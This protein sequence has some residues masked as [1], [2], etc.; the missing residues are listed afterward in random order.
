MQSMNPYI[1]AKHQ[2]QHQHRKIRGRGARDELDGN[3]YDGDELEE[4][5]EEKIGRNSRKSKSKGRKA[6]K[7]KEMTLDIEHENQED[8]M[9]DAPNRQRKR[10]S[11]SEERRVSIN[12]LDAALGLDPTLLDPPESTLLDPP[13]SPPPPS[14]RSKSAP[15][16]RPSILDRMIS[17]DALAS[18]PPAS[19]F[20]KVKTTV[21]GLSAFKTITSTTP[22]AFLQPQQPDSVPTMIE[23]AGERRRRKSSRRKSTDVA[24][25]KTPEVLPLTEGNL[26]RSGLQCEDVGPPTRKT[27]KPIP[28][29]D[30]PLVQKRSRPRA[31]SLGK[32]RRRRPST[33][34]GQ[35]ESLEKESKSRV[36][37][38][39]KPTDSDITQ[40][41]DSN[42]SR[43]SPSL[44]KFVQLRVIAQ[45]ECPKPYLPGEDSPVTASFLKVMKAQSPTWGALAKELSQGMHSVEMPILSFSHPTSPDETIQ[46]GCSSG[47][48]RRAILMSSGHEQ[49]VRRMRDALISSMNFAKS[50]ITELLDPTKAE[51]FDVFRRVSQ[52]MNSFD[53]LLIYFVGTSVPHSVA[54]CYD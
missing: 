22:A 9:L 17:D 51:I 11:I 52:T 36:S 13:E 31:K 35:G 30:R 47:G 34:G 24:S 10:F 5:S 25:S 18:P 46:F 7:E 29:H 2:H 19:A 21:R 48:Q 37:N 38:K 15:R 39:T 12:R 43:Q 6:K 23:T 49:Q 16:D 26:T 54:N 20:S 41:N 33:R 8:A 44:Y 3:I 50:S 42:S 14:H 45:V 1:S 32:Q 40:L 53:S 28:Q 27:S 4:N